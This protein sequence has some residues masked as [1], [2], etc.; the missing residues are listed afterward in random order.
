MKNILATIAALVAMV[1][2]VHAESF[3]RAAAGLYQPKNPNA[4]FNANVA[5]LCLYPAD[6][7]KMR[8]LWAAGEI[9]AA[10]SV[11]TCMMA[12]KPMEVIQTGGDGDRLIKVALVRDGT[13]IDLWTESQ[14]FKSR[15]GWL[16]DMCLNSGQTIQA[17][18]DR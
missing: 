11:K 12:A 6:V 1:T 2:A 16:F 15:S 13:V 14:L 8:D 17:C 4:V 7:G 5:W 9:K 18:A 3:E 10:L